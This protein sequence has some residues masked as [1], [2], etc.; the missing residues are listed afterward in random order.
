VYRSDITTRME[1]DSFLDQE[2]RAWLL[3]AVG[4]GSDTRL[5][6]AGLLT[7]PP[8]GS[9]RVAPYPSRSISLPLLSP[10][11]LAGTGGPSGADLSAGAFFTAGV[12]G[13]GNG[14]GV[15]IGGVEAPPLWLRGGAGTPSGGGSLSPAGAGGGPHGRTGGGPLGMPPAPSRANVRSTSRSAHD[16]LVRA[17]TRGAGGFLGGPSAADVAGGSR[18]SS[19]VAPRGGPAASGGNSGGGGGPGMGMG[20]SSV[21]GGAS[22]SLSVVVVE[23]GSP[24]GDSLLDVTRVDSDNTLELDEAALAYSVATAE[25]VRV[26]CRGAGRGGPLPLS[27]AL[28]RRACARTHARARAT[29][30]LSFGRVVCSLPRTPAHTTARNPQRAQ[31]CGFPWGGGVYACT[32]VTQTCLRPPPPALSLPLPPLPAPSPVCP[33]SAVQQLHPKRGLAAAG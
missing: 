29:C 33:F 22:V 23:P 2:T 6:E 3:R 13:G 10:G 4:A 14:G 26:V 11:A 25:N 7:G 27:C 15:G 21:S 30:S 5:Q 28:R 20:V 31:L 9:P 1:Q 18:V 16:V 8:S 32:L 24:V 19:G 12:G 17:S